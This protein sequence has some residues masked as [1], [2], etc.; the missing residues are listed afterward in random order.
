MIKK[1]SWNQFRQDKKI[2]IILFIIFT[3]ISFY[4]IYLVLSTPLGNGRLIHYLILFVTFAFMV[5]FI[6]KFLQYFTNFIKR[7]WIFYLLQFLLFT[8]IK[9]ELAPV[10]IY[11]ENQQRQY[12]KIPK[13]INL[14]SYH[15]KDIHNIY[16]FSTPN[17]FL[18]GVNT[19]SIDIDGEQVF[20]D[21]RDKTWYQFHNDMYQYYQNK[22]SKPKSIEKYISFQ[23]QPDLSFV[24]FEKTD[25]KW[26][27]AKDENLKK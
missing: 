2:S 14:A 10:I 13:T 18:I 11:I 5:F 25:K 17:N 22:K 27:K 9:N 24:S 12:G 23:M 6:L 1:N 16:Y 15:F 7:P 8:T 19:P 20:Y 26:I 4:Q 3:T 21:S